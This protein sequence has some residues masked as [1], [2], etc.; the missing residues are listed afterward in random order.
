MCAFPEG[1]HKRIS[2][3]L[4]LIYR[5]ASIADAGELLQVTSSS[6]YLESLLVSFDR[7]VPTPEQLRAFFTIMQQSSFCDTLVTFALR[8]HVAINQGSPHSLD[9]HTLSPLLQ[10]RNLERVSINISYGHAAIDN[11]LLKEITLPWP[12][13]RY[14]SLHPYQKARLSHSKVNLQGLSYLAQHCHSLQSVS[15]QFD[16]SLPAMYPDK[17]IRC[18]SLTQLF[19]S[20]SY[21]SDPLAVAT[22]LADVFPNLKLDH[23]YLIRTRTGP[24]TMWDSEVLHDYQ[25]T[26]ECIEMAARWKDVNQML[27]ARRKELSRS[28][29][30]P[31]VRIQSLIYNYTK[32]SSV[33]SKP[34]FTI[35]FRLLTL[36]SLFF[37][38]AFR[39]FIVPAF[40]ELVYSLHV[41][42]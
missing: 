9:A 37:W 39:S 29:M 10:C 11:S 15:L 17:G 12:C 8:D 16:V 14:I 41:P 2:W 22:F 33:I 7:I 32:Y 21:V 27:E 26:P 42:Y 3:I 40:I 5:L 38:N 23:S 31:N 30:N 13:L 36:E 19:V 24:R 4:P 35:K 20:H 25:K 28:L 18:E 1:L 34:P 6:S